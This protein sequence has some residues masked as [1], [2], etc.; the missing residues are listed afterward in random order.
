MLKKAHDLF[1]KYV[2]VDNSNYLVLYNLY[3]KAENLL[4]RSDDLRPAGSQEE[5]AVI[6][7]VNALFTDNIHTKIAAGVDRDKINEVKDMITKY[8]TFD[9]P[10]TMILYKLCIKALE[11]LP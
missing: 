11:L 6:D 10:N 3:K 1:V 9:N 2:K 7:A 8:L 5:Q 4:S